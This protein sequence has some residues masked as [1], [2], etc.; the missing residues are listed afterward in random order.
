LVDAGG[1]L[2]LRSPQDGARRSLEIVGLGDWID[3]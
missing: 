2:R 3:D 1:D